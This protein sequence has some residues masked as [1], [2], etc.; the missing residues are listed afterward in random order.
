[1]E[2]CL[3]RETGKA[4]GFVALQG[5]KVWPKP[6]RAKLM[7]DRGNFDVNALQTGLAYTTS[8][9]NA[10]TSTSIETDIEAFIIIEESCITPNITVTTMAHP[11]SRRSVVTAPVL[12]CI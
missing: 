11:A 10:T 9:A 4:G 3:S 6:N 8:A 1:M 7:Q 2:I 5:D 12:I